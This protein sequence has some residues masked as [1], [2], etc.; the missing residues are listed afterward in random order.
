MEHSSPLMTINSQW[1]ENYII[2]DDQHSVGQL[3][4]YLLRKQLGPKSK[5]QHY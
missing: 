2:L 5:Y 1:D 3:L 4:D